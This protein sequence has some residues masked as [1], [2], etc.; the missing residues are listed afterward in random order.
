[1]HLCAACFWFFSYEKS[2]ELVTELSLSGQYSHSQI[3]TKQFKNECKRY[4]VNAG[5]NIKLGGRDCDPQ[6]AKQKSWLV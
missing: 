2:R 6:D 4:Y 3:K 1:M 5:I